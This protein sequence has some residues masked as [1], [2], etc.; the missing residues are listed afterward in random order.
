MTVDRKLRLAVLGAVSLALTSCGGGDEAPPAAPPTIAVPATPIPPN[1][2]AVYAKTCSTATPAVAAVGPFRTYAG[3][4]LLS[5][6]LAGAEFEALGKFALTASDKIQGDVLATFRSHFKDEFDVVVFIWDFTNP[7]PSAPVGIYRQVVEA[8]P[9]R[10]I[11]AIRT[12][13]PKLLGMMTITFSKLTFYGLD[14]YRGGPTL[15]ELAHQ[16]ANRVVPTVSSGHWGFSSVGGQLGGW[17]ADTFKDLGE[18]RYQ[19][20]PFG[21]AANRGNSAAYAPLELYLMGLLPA[22]QVPDIKVANDAQWVDAAKGVFSASG[23]TTYTAR[24]IADLMGEQ[25]PDMSTARTHFRLATIV[26]TDKER[27][28]E[29]DAAAIS[30]GAAHFAYPGEPG[31]FAPP[32]G[33]PGYFGGFNFWSATGGRATAQVNELSVLA[34]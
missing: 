18:N 34:R 16:V 20:A 4:C 10:C 31:T 7:P 27:L 11:N 23:L 22:E 2:R 30:Q 9:L 19:A 17:R 33:S 26:L 6:Q 15:H 8:K 28:T 5:Y 21:V 1:S 24:Q 25:R 14:P 32:D 13:C 12:D 3:D 29:A